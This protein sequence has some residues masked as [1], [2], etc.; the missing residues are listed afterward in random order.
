MRRFILGA[1]LLAVLLMGCLGV[2]WRMESVHRPVTDELIRAAELSR[3]GNGDAAVETVLHAREL[4]E[5][6]W[7][8][9]AAFADHGPM[10]QIDDLFYALDAY[11]PGTADYA[12]CCL[13]LAQRTE[14]MAKD[15]ALNWWNLL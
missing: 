10:E 13:Q 4:W 11:D 3:S 7:R 6:H 1:S 14:A 2:W 5:K 12:A 8:F 9:T 15:H